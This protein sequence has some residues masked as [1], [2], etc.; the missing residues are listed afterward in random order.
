MAPTSSSPTPEPDGSQRGRAAGGLLTFGIA[1]ALFFPGLALHESLHL[2][3]LHLVGGQGSIVVRPWSFALVDLTLPSLHVQ[4]VP[5]LDFGRQ[6]AVNF[7][8]PA[9]AA[10]VFAIPLLYLQD[11]RLRL[12]FGASVAVLIFYAV[13]ESADLLL[14]YFMN[15]DFPALVTPEFNYGVP[16]AIC[17][18]AGFMAAYAAQSTRRTTS[19]GSRSS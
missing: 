6:L 4:P 17:V 12:A 8:G 19:A 14:D 16:L 1:F 18:A 2:L 3:V 5:P 10:G 7:F 13:I 11:K 9:L 15:F